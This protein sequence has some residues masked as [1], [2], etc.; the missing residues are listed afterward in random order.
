MKEPLVEVIVLNTN[1]G[2]HI[3]GC[4][5]GLKNTKYGNLRVSVVDQN[6]SDG[7]PEL[8]ERKYRWVNL[9]RN[10][11]NNG[12]VGGCNQ[13]LRKSKARYCVL[14][15]D[16]TE[17]DP[18]WIRELVRVAEKDESI[19]A[20]QPKIRS[21]RN[22]KMFEYAGAG[23]GYM[24]RYGFELCRGRVFFDVEEDKG[25][26]DDLRGVFWCCGVAMF[27]RMDVLKK[28]GYLDDDFFIYY[29]ETDLCWR[30]NLAGYKQV[31]VPTSVVYHLGSATMGDLNKGFKFSKIFLLHRNGW[32]TVLKNYSIKTWFRIVPMKILLELIA[33]LRFLHVQPARSAAIL[34][35]NLWILVHPFS[36]FKKN[37][38]TARL[39][40]VSDREIMRG[41]IKRNIPLSYFISGKKK[42]SDYLLF[43]EDYKKY[44]YKLH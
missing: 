32:T 19:A 23:G 17:Q 31:Y 27:L 6:S 14:L 28:I 7:S 21:L 42:F 39:R 8:I 3:E 5:K 40:K 26:Y 11:I 18:N 43:I 24:D 12:F 38:R 44:D 34:T 4:L 33:F 2:K 20:L 41:M 36:A 37:R 30:M 15:N 35:A 13:I 1:G 22:K 10:K 29:E 25:Q 9:V 16:D